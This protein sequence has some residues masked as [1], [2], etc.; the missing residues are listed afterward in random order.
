MNKNLILLLG[1]IFQSNF[2]TLSLPYKLTFAITY[3]CNQK[4]IYCNIW[5]KPERQEL[6]IEDF[7]RFFRNS[8]ELSWI[9]LTGGEIFLRDDLLDIIRIIFKQSKH[10][11]LVQFPTNGY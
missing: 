3:Q 7:D 11:Y 9:H 5:N 4:C 8:D 1:K 6:S 2:Q 10:L